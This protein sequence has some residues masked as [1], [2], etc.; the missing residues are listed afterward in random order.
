M[1]EP[2][3]WLIRKDGYFYRPKR[4]GYTASK[5]EAGRYTQADA[6]KECLIEP[7]GII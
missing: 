2:L 6:E 7:W 1:G 4:S 5:V 3:E